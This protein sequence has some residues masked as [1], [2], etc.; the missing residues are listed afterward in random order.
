M[1]QR[2]GFSDVDSSPGRDTLIAYL[3]GTAVLLGDVKARLKASLQL[4]TDS[5]F[6]DIGCGLGQDVAG[7]ERA[8]GVDLSLT[9]LAEAKR[10]WPRAHVIAAD[11]HRLPFADRSF[12]G[13][14]IERV[15][16]HVSEP[17]VVLR[18]A[19]RT[20][21]PDGRIAIWEPDFESLLFDATDVEVSRVV[22]IAAGARCAQG[23]LGRELGRLLTEAGFADIDVTLEPGWARSFED[24]RRIFGFDFVIADLLSSGKVEE[25]RMR[26]WLDEL[27]D[28]AERGTF[29]LHFSRFFATGIRPDD[30]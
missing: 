14:R 11:G 16:I 21:Q 17:A 8:V 15:L 10:R 5:R 29:W 3:D 9:L 25:R 23:R 1:A 18:E 2:S 6:L 19:H 13:C 27:E 12:A 20:L 30:M 22:V 26:A 7:D 28:R 24:V 4:S